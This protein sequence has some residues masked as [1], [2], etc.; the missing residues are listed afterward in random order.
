MKKGTS[1][2]LTKEQKADL[3]ALE[4]LPD[5]Q[6]DTSEI[7]ELT[8]WTDARR[9]LFYRPVKQQIT[10]RLDSDVVDWFKRNA[11]G[12]RGYQTEINRALRRHVQRCET[13]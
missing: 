7:P 3:A 6:I 13:S 12:G 1:E 8:D 4:A 2:K 5:E 11:P 9:S 10:L